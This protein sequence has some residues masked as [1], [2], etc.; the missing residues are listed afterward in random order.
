[1]VIYYIYGNEIYIIYLIYVINGNIIY[2]DSLELNIFQ[3]KFKNS[4][5]TKYNYKYL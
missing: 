2:F 3:K 1:M 5:K 4:Y